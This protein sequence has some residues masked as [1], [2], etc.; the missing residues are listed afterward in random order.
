MYPPPLPSKK[1]NVGVVPWRYRAGLFGVMSPTHHP[2]KPRENCFF[3]LSSL[4][5]GFAPPINEAH[6]PGRI[7][8]VLHPPKFDIP[9]K[10][11]NERTSQCSSVGSG[12]H[13]LPVC[14]HPCFSFHYGRISHLFFTR[15][16]MIVSSVTRVH[17]CCHC[18]P[19]IYAVSPFMMFFLFASHSLHMPS[20]M[21]AN[22]SLV[23][24]LST[25]ASPRQC[26]PSFPALALS[27]RTL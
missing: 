10:R 11:L 18:P 19:F 7:A 27:L 17:V 2:L 23:C 9:N 4:N 8:Q 13:S 21:K 25:F 3:S 12:T 16:K 14:A 24:H 22:L 15:V 20:I 5:A 26:P 6:L 1:Q